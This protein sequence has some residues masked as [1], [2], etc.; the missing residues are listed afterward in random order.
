[1]EE[2]FEFFVT[3]INLTWKVIKPHYDIIIETKGSGLGYNY[4]IL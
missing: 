4:L 2:S 1:M 3:R